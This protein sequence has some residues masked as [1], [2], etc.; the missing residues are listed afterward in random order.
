M[1]CGFLGDFAGYFCSPAKEW[2]IRVCDLSY[3]AESRV[4]TPVWLLVRQGGSSSE[5]HR[6]ADT[7][8]SPGDEPDRARLGWAQQPQMSMPR[9]PLGEETG[10][11]ANSELPLPGQPMPSPPK[12]QGQ[13]A[14]APG[15]NA[16]AQT[17]PPAAGGQLPAAAEAVP[18]GQA[19]G[20]PT[21]QAAADNATQPKPDGDDNGAWSS[22]VFGPG[23]TAATCCEICG[24]GSGPP[25]DYCVA[26][27]LSVLARNRPTHVMPI[28]FER[29]G[30]D[31]S[32]PPTIFQLAAKFSFGSLDQ[33]ISPAMN[34]T[35]GHFLEHD[36]NNRDEFVEFTFWGLDRWHSNQAIDSDDYFL[37][38]NAN[39]QPVFVSHNLYSL[40]PFSIGGFNRADFQSISDASRLNNFELNY[41]WGLA[42]RPTD[43][44]SIPA[45]AGGGNVNPDCSSPISSAPE[46]WS[47]T[48]K[49]S[50]S[51]RGST[52]METSSGDY[53]VH[54]RNTMLGM[55]VGGEC[56]YRQCRWSTDLHGRA[57]GYLNISQCSS[58]VVTHAVGVDPFAFEDL[59]ANP[60][61]NRDVTAEEAEI[62]VAASY[63]IRPNLIGRVSY[64]FIWMG[65]L[66][67]APEQF[68]FDADPKPHIT[69]NGTMFVNGVS[70]SLEYTW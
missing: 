44:C 19:T 13:P 14:S 64:D 59:N 36:E 9:Q 45:D 30:G 1:E 21:T 25:P 58:S 43:S 55:Q 29:N 16:R 38:Y 3:P 8:R 69:N 15:S 40:F 53:N 10:V 18:P 66:A 63:K 4:S 11:Q 22:G 34:M 26:G 51:A 47:S 61:M 35:V 20:R 32:V 17:Q 48:T 68:V 39:L 6:A 70:F 33:G 46:S 27:G 56:T 5:L 62:G 41:R 67:L 12:A 31:P 50:S 7:G 57:G 23:C 37:G 54:T 60:S 24:G 52:Q 42:G 65:G 28:S 49:R 2:S